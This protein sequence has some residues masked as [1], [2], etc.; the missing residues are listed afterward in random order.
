[1]ATSFDEI[2]NL[3]M[4]V[5]RDY[6]INELFDAADLTNF[7]N[8]MAGFLKRAMTRFTNC[9]YNLEDYADFEGGE[10]TV[11]LTLTEQTIVADLLV[12]EW[13]SSKILDVTQMQLHLNDTDFRHYSEAQNLKE[14][15]SA[16]EILREVV[17]QD[18]QNY[19]I[20]RIPWEDWAG[21]NFFGT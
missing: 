8:F 1:M 5:I 20:K 17:N 18:M 12:I 14:K 2:Y 4:V 9:Q 21:G 15:M 3:S 7:E 13:L 11:T 6:Q 19:G 16:R 10:F